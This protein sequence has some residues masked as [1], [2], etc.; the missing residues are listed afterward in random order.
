MRAIFRK[1]PLRLNIRTQ[2]SEFREIN[3]KQTDK[4][5]LQNFS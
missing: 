1:F 3:N 2:F 5:T 4:S